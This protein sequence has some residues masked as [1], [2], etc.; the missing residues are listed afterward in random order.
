MNKIED[1]KA[2][3]DLINLGIDV[4]LQ[5]LDLKEDFNEYIRSIYDKI[6]IYNVHGDKRFIIGGTGGL[7]AFRSKFVIMI[8]SKYLHCFSIQDTVA[9]FLLNELGLLSDYYIDSLSVEGKS[10]IFRPCSTCGDDCRKC[11][12]GGFIL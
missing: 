6:Q 2:I 7:N 11:C 10:K 12:F 8:C 5:G 4:L 3:D 9:T 1:A